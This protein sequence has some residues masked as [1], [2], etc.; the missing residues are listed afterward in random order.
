MTKLKTVLA[1]AARTLSNSASPRLDAQLLLMHIL[2]KPRSWLIAH[3]DDSVSEA[4]CDAFLALIAQRAQGIPLAYLTGHK[5]FWSLSLKV[6]AHTL[7][8]R[9]E[10][11][12]L[13][14]LT[15]E[16][17]AGRT[18][19]QLLELGCG[20]GAISIALAHER[21]D[22]QITAVDYSA[23][24]LALAQENVQRCGIQNIR[25]LQS[26]WFS[27][28]TKTETFDAII[29]NPP[30]IAEGDPHLNREDIRHE[31]LIA[32]VGGADGL[33]A[34]RHIIAHSPH[35]LKAQGWLLLEHGYDQRLAVHQLLQPHFGQI[36]CW[37]DL[38]GVDRVSMGQLH[39]SA[40]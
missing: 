28:L 4:Q 18:H 5:E 24:A 17:L 6:N 8:P 19:C 11:E 30:Y 34:I 23:P 26:D 21:P 1:E 12:R 7:I 37:R 16:T 25:L 20:S 14:E 3:D 38:A 27:Q 22:W 40:S 13:V 31:P 32:L 35:Y 2:A 33:E 39:S 15:L 9:P 10:T 29:S 36:Q